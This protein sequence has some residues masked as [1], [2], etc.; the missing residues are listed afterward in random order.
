MSRRY[1]RN[2]K[3]KH[4]LEL[5]RQSDELAQA[6]ENY[7]FVKRS[8]RS[9]ESELNWVLRSLGEYSIFRAPAEIG[10]IDAD[11][12]RL[13]QYD[14]DPIYLSDGFNSSLYASRYRLLHAL[15]VWTEKN[16]S[17]MQTLVHVR[18]TNPSRPEHWSYAISPE[19]YEMVPIETLQD[20]LAKQLSYAIVNGRKRVA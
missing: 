7:N 15:M 2:Q 6:N 9:I 16:V 14:F 18:Y 20:I 1:G 19:A 10:R 4:L 12:V 17:H 13:I 5:K 3:R 8:L 11:E